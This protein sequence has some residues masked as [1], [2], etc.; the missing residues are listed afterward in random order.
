MTDSNL[1]RYILSVL[2]LAIFTFS[3][4]AQETDEDDFQRYES[5]NFEFRIQ[6]PVDWE[7]VEDTA[8]PLIMMRN[9]ED[10]SIIPDSGELFA[11]IQFGS[12]E[13]FATQTDDAEEVVTEHLRSAEES[14]IGGINTVSLAGLSIAYVQAEAIYSGSDKLILFAVTDDGLALNVSA[15]VNTGEIEDFEPILI[16][17]LSSLIIPDYVVERYTIE[18]DDSYRGG[19]LNPTSF[20]YPDNWYMYEVNT[21]VI[22]LIN[23]R[24]DRFTGQDGQIAVVIVAGPTFNADMIMDS[25]PNEWLSD[26]I[27]Q[28]NLPHNGIIM[29]ITLSK[30]SAAFIQ[31]T[32]SRD[33]Q[34]IVFAIKMESG[35]A[36]FVQV[37]ANERTYRSYEPTIMQIISTLEYSR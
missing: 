21:S 28:G 4:N 20:N 5:P 16:K 37:I 34:R 1:L 35:V 8:S 7:L 18:L 10:V 29:P 19:V 22:N 17:I 14:A 12:V 33:V 31:N 30:R 25:R 27:A 36:A 15:W 32:D 6:I 13:Q 26:F 2:F 24:R 3:V 9:G 23:V 11:F